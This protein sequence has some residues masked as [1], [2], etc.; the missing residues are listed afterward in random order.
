MSTTPTDAQIEAAAR[1]YD[2]SAFGLPMPPF[3]PLK[4]PVFFQSEE[5]RQELAREKVRPILTAALAVTPALSGPDPD[6]G[7]LTDAETTALIAAGKGETAPSVEDA[8]PGRRSV[9]VDDIADALDGTINRLDCDDCP[10]TIARIA[11]EWRAD[12]GRTLPVDATTA[13]SVEDAR[14]EGRESAS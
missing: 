11:D 7:V 2:P 12:R 3:D 6:G 14:A 1:A 5:D 13:P 9:N 8:Q 4:F 10:Q